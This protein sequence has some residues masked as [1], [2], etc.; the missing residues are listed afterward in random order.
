MLS[1]EW[2]FEKR[3]K[4]EQRTKDLR[5]EQRRDLQEFLKKEKRKNTPDQY[6]FSS[7]DRGGGG[8]PIRALDGSIVTSIRHVSID[9]RKLREQKEIKR[10]LQ[11]QIEEKERRRMIEVA[12]QREAEQRDAE[13]I[14]AQQQELSKTKKQEQKVVLK[15]DDLWKKAEQEALKRKNKLRM[16][17]ERNESPTVKSHVKSNV[18]SPVRK[19]PVQKPFEKSVFEKLNELR[20]DLEAE[21]KRVHKDLC[22]SNSSLDLD[23]LENMQNERL[24]LFN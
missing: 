22:R 23:Y 3:D 4:I 8:A 18:K 6:W 10:A 19:L 16:S 11:A 12:A 1:G 17:P 7:T 20:R 24:K 13:R 15:Q 5:E 21:K 9:E 14:I 2:F